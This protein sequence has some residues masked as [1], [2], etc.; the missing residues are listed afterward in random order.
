MILEIRRLLRY[1]W[2]QIPVYRGVDQSLTGAASASS[3]Y[4]HGND[5][6][7]DVPDQNAPDLTHIQSEQAVL[8]LIR[9]VNEYPGKLMIITANQ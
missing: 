7:G 5:G 4:Y 2:R 9:L 3:L 8:G 6:L 1:H